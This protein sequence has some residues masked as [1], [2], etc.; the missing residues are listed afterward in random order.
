MLGAWFVFVFS[1]IQ[2]ASGILGKQGKLVGKSFAGDDDD[3]GEDVVDDDEG[4]EDQEEQATFTPATLCALLKKKLHKLR[5][6]PT[7]HENGFVK[8][9]EGRWASHR[10]F[11][12]MRD[13]WLPDFLRPLVDGWKKKLSEKSYARIGLAWK[14][15][16]DDNSVEF[17]QKLVPTPN[18]KGCYTGIDS[19]R[20]SFTS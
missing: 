11:E 13:E 16:S 9:F 17:V 8:S 12:A 4:D 5:G 14:L 20:Y 15:F 10:N 19:T 18:A 6:K 3:D 2:I 7:P 1:N